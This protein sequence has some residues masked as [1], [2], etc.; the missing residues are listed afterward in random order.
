[1][2]LQLNNALLF[3]YFNMEKKTHK[4][5][6]KNVENF[7]SGVFKTRKYKLRIYN[8]YNASLG[9]QSSPVI[10]TTFYTNLTIFS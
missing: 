1:M 9:I 2:I 7:S 5:F 10:L 4:H 3:N 6:Q 8:T